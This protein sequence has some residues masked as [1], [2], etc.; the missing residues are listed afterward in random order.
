MQ[1]CGNQL[2]LRRS[3]R[4]IRGAP[5]H[6]RRDDVAGGTIAASSTAGAVG[7]RR[8]RRVMGLCVCRPSASRQDIERKRTPDKAGYGPFVMNSVD[9][10]ERA[11]EDFRAGRFGEI[12][13]VVA[14]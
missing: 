8:R 6:R 10:I 5:R 9:E 1:R 3:E 14:E 7:L 11:Y 12:A 4:L 13:P 2:T